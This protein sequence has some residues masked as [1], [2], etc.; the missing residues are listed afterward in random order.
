MVSVKINLLEGCNVFAASDWNIQKLDVTI[1]TIG[2]DYAITAGKK[3]IER[4]HVPKEV[5][6]YCAQ[7]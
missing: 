2:K 7:K 5:N 4:L 1:K 6:A 3:D